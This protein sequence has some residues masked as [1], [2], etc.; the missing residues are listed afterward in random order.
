MI[1]KKEKGKKN[2]D[3]PQRE[4]QEDKQWA[5]GVKPTHRMT[6]NDMEQ[7]S[8]YLTITRVGE[9]QNRNRFTKEETEK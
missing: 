7:P 1:G 2:K 6:K 3:K 9:R 5:T 4:K 8:K